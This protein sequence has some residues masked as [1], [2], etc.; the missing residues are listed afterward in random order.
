MST[1]LLVNPLF[2]KIPKVSLLLFDVISPV[3]FLQA[4]VVALS[5]LVVTVQVSWYLSPVCAMP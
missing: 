5:S 3:E 4:I 2:V 1:D